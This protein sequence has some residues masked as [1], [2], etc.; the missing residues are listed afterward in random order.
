[1]DASGLNMDLDSYLMWLDLETLDPVGNLSVSE[2]PA[3][4]TE[5]LVVY[6]EK[7]YIGVNNAFD[8]GNEVGLVGQ[9]DPFTDEYVEWDLGAEGKNPI[10]LFAQND[11]II[12]VNN[13]DYASTSLSWI[14][15][16]DEEATTHIVAE[17]NAG[18]LAAV[19][20]SDGELRYQV[21]GEAAVRQA[22]PSGFDRLQRSGWRMRTGIL[23]NG[24]RPGVG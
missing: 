19:M 12:S 24:H 22:E 21:S 3:Y 18:C 23:R 9:Y 10:H 14:A 5:G 1:M 15:I 20:T 13:R 11:Q 8:W 6:D 7:L 2:G 16:G 4:A 17:S